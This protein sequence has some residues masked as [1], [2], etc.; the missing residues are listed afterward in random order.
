MISDTTSHARQPRPSR[1][2]ASVRRTTLLV[3]LASLAVGLAAWAPT[4]TAAPVRAQ[5]AHSVAPHA[6]PIVVRVASR[7]G[8]SKILVAA[9]GASL[10]RDTNDGPNDPTCTG[11]C[12]TVWPPLVLP[13]GDKKPKGGAGVTG[14]GTVMIANGQLQ[15]T[16]HT[17]P[18]YTFS[19]DSGHSV[20]G[21]GVGPFLVV[22]P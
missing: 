21:N 18:L 19:G 4:A 10:Y 2:T 11:S 22:K 15:V 8:F 12:A 13:K 14:L 17:E 3:G 9:A 7:K 1:L 5:S 16:F 6:A 20:D